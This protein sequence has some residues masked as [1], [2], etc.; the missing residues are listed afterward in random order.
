MRETSADPDAEFHRA[1]AEATRH[2]AEQAAVAGV[3]RLVFL[4]SIKVNGEATAGRPFTEADPPAPQDAYARSKLAAEAA[5]WAVSERSGLEVVVIRPPLVYG[6]GV[7]ANFLRLMRL[8][9]K[10]VTLP[11]G[12]AENRRSLV[13]IWN[14]CDLIAC[15]VR[16]PAAA[17]ET[18]LVSDGRDVSSAELVRLLASGMGRPVRLL[19]IPAGVLLSAAHMIGRG[20]PVERLF[21]SL[22]VDPSKADRVLGWRPPVPVE[23]GLRRTALW[24]VET[25]GRGE[26]R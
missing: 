23:E 16:H 17:G 5:L 14:L 9:A 15:C 3:K 19:P 11:F 26:W 1:N 21:G 25:E 24:F 20:G 6:P 2:L 13:G 10:G 8:I 18:F 4:S 7:K 22:Q 12:S